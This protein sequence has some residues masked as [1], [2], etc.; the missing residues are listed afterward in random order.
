MSTLRLAALALVSV[1][2]GAALGAVLHQPVAPTVAPERVQE[3]M[4]EEAPVRESKQAR[5][6]AGCTGYAWPYIPAECLERVAAAP[7]RT[8]ADVV[9]AVLTS[10]PSIRTTTAVKQPTLRTASR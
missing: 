2:C 8:V 1:A 10:D 7:R 5:L 9:P 6:D 3:R 4:P